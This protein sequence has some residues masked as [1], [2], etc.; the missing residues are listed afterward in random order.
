[1]ND[2]ATAARTLVRKAEANGGLAPLDLERFWEDQKQS[3][4]DPFGNRI[5]Q[6]PLGIMMSHECVFAEL[7]A[8]EDWRRLEHDP[9]WRAALCKEYNDKAEKTVGR[10]LLNETVADPALRY[11]PVK[12]LHEIFEAENIWHGESYWLKQSA[13]DED[14]LAALLDRVERRL[15]DGLRR[16]L[17][18]DNWDEEKARL[19]ALGI[20]PSLYR[21]QRGP[22]TFATSIFGI[23]N[24]IFLIHDNEDLAVRF[25]D[26]I[27]RAMLERARILDA[28]AGYVP[29]A[30]PRGFAFY[31]DNCCLLAP[32]M[33]ELFGYPIL[34]RIFARYSPDPGDNRYQH[35]D[36]AMGHLLP[37]LGRLRLTGVN[38]GPTLTVDE[39]RAH[40]PAAVIYGQLAPFTFSRNE[41]EG[42]VAEFLRDFAQ[43]R[44]ARGLVFAT[45]GS[46]NN[47]SRLSG[48]RLIMAAIQ[49]HGRYDR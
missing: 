49:E 40:L 27:L 46:I 44:A 37:L 6:A 4:A 2:N 21:A 32:D 11:P 36:S 26:L 42:I 28:E 31:D 30:A 3:L 18:P 22:V 25:R 19:A 43:A 34:E 17:L 12:G 1:M 8:A 41:E 33:Y 35:S 38:F 10:R 15:N 23:E 45:A 5:P 7:G 20:K 47:G 24:L 48:M 16:F 29:E 14:E 13:H 39:I 9:V